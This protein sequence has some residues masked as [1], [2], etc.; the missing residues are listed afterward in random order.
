VGR[1]EH[2]VVWIEPYWK[3]P[4]EAPLTARVARVK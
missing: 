2:H 4:E 1:L 3:G